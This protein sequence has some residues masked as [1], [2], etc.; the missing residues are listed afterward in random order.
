[1]GFTWKFWM[2]ALQTEKKTYQKKSNSSSLYKGVSNALQWF[3]NM[4]HNAAAPDASAKVMKVM[5][6]MKVRDAELA[7]T[8]SPIPRFASIAWNM[9]FESTI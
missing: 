5:I 2:F 3:G 4:K 6:L 1:M 7:Y 8:L 9:A